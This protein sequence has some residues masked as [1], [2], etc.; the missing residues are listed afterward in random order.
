MVSRSTSDRKRK[1]AKIGNRRLRASDIP[2]GGNFS[3]FTRRA[4][5]LTGE[6]HLI[7]EAIALWATGESSFPADDMEQITL[8]K[9]SLLE[10]AREFT[11]VGNLK[12]G[13]KTKWSPEARS[14]LLDLVDS[15]V[16]GKRFKTAVAAIEH[17]RIA[18]TRYAAT[19]TARLANVV[20]ETRRRFQLSLDEVET[21]IA[22]L[23][24]QII[25]LESLSGTASPM[26]FHRPAPVGGMSARLAAEQTYAESL[27]SHLMGLIHALTKSSPPILS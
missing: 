19:S 18:D 17:V 9:R 2:S 23:E 1:I 20:S 15:L 8:L 10:I 24:S 5:G 27:L 21:E 14:K 16:D 26:P 3:F 25:E 6:D 11:L 22:T 12:S 7:A 13:A 4:D